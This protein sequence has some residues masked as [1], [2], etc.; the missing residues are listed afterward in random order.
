MVNDEDIRRIVREEFGRIPSS[1]PSVYERTQSLIRQSVQSASPTTPI[2][3]IAPTGQAISSSMGVSR[4][5]G[6]SSRTGHPWRL[7]PNTTTQR[8]KQKA[9]KI[10]EKSIYVILLNYPD[11]DDEETYGFSESM[12]LVKGYVK[13]KSTDDYIVIKDKL[14]Q[15]FK[16]RYPNLDF[17]SF[18]YL[19]RERQNL[20][21][22]LVPPDW[23]SKGLIWAGQSILSNKKRLFLASLRRR[24][25][26]SRY[27]T[28]IFKKTKFIFSSSRTIE[29]S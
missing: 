24:R 21:V 20:S 22:P 11:S 15:L 25:Y 8:G 16:E 27:R 9:V 3:P 6:S 29:T 18:E 5:R 14:A 10:V 12:V 2:A 4:G 28:T 26:K 13:I 17:D 7:S 19:K 23:E 1:S